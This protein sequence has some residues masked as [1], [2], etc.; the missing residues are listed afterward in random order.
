M[1][2]TAATAFLTGEYA[3]MAAS[4]KFTTDQTTTAY[5]TAIDMAL[6]QLGVQETD[7]AT[8][9][10]DQSQ[11]KGYIALLNY[12]ALKRFVRLFSLQFDV[13]IGNNTVFAYRSQIFKSMQQLLADAEQECLKLG[14]DVG[15]GP[16]FQMGQIN[17]DYNEPGWGIAENVDLWGW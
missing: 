1:D 12:Y 16:S 2:R 3:E 8:A 10:V 6:R 5:N 14:Y 13:N 9:D 7:L 17:L 11:V 4:A 15:G